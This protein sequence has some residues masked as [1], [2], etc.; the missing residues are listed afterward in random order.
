VLPDFEQD[1]H[2]HFDDEVEDMEAPV[3]E[4]AVPARPVQDSSPD[5]SSRTTTPKTTVTD[6]D[7]R[8]A[9]FV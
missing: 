7:I 8:S 9:V 4:V 6:D 1:G 3:K 2:V 5:M